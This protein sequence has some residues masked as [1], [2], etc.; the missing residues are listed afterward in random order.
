M[1]VEQEQKTVSALP[2]TPGPQGQR[3]GLLKWEL[4]SKWALN[5]SEGPS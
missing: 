5:L 2:S 4:W 3:L 1:V